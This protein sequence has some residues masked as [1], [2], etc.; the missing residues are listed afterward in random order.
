MKFQ[1][2]AR[3]EVEAASAADAAAELRRTLESQ[4]YSPEIDAK[5]L[6]CRIEVDR[7]GGEP[8]QETMIPLAAKHGG[9]VVAVDAWSPSVA[10]LFPDEASGLAFLRERER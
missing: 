9:E 4:G 2:R 5:P 7:K 1:L 8:I 6:E 3:V 10:F